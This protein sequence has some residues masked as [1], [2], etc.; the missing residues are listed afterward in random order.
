METQC[1]TCRAPNTFSIFSDCQNCI[2]FYAVAIEWVE[3]GLNTN[4]A[5]H[6]LDCICCALVC[7]TYIPQVILLV[8]DE[9]NLFFIRYFMRCHEHCKIAEKN[10]SFMSINVNFYWL[11]LCRLWWVSSHILGNLCIE[12]FSFVRLFVRAVFLNFVSVN[13]SNI[14]SFTTRFRPADA[15]MVC[16]SLAWWW[17]W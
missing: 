11:R 10:M 14:L 3:I 6:W 15:W 9:R 8:A 4:M 16:H 5:W 7:Y 1:R 13:W 17:K 12:G 2:V